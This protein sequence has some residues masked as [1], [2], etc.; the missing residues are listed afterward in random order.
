M[1]YNGYWLNFNAIV[2]RLIITSH[3]D[4][5]HALICYTSPIVRPPCL[6]YHFYNFVNTIVE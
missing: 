3:C 5:E 2:N 1:Q 4:G 6:C